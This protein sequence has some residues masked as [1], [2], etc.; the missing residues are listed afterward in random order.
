MLVGVLLILTGCGD[1]TPEIDVSDEQLTL[2]AGT[3]VNNLGLL[4][5]DPDVWR[6]RL[7][8][9]CTEGVWEPEVAVELGEEFI[10]EDMVLSVRAGGDTPRAEEGAQALWLI[11]VNVC[12]DSFPD[13]EIEKG[14]PFFTG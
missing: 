14:P 4:Q 6:Q 12:R 1:S 10:D 13:G 7:V 11:A 8:R 3:W 9:A 5:T 2:Q